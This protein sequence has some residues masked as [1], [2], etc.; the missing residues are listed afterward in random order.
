MKITYWHYD[1]NIKH[2]NA[3]ALEY[4]VPKT[5]V[6]TRPGLELDPYTTFT[7]R[8]L[9]TDSLLTLNYSFSIS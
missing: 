4:V 2:A 5:M 7:L 9:N 8:I 3:T 6:L 1:L